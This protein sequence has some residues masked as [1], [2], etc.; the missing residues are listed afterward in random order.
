VRTSAAHPLTITSATSK[1]TR[2]TYPTWQQAVDENEDARVWSGIHVRTS[3]EVGSQLG[4]RVA[5][6]DLAHR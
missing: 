4:R 6:Y 2:R 3:D 5:T 1:G